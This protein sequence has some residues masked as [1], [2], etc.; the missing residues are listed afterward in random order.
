MIH[1][2]TQNDI[3]KLGEYAK[4]D[5]REISMYKINKPSFA[6]YAGKRANRGLREDSL[7]LTRIDKVEEFRF[8]Y[9]ILKASGN[10]L[11]ITIGTD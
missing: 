5:Y 9:E 1:S 10:Y 8:N 7:I 6:F 2:S 3:K 11:I 4:D